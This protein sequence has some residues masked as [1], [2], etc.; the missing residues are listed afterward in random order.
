MEEIEAP[1]PIDINNKENYLLESKEYELKLDNDIYLLKMELKLND[2]ISLKIRQINDLSFY[3]YSKD[4]KYDNLAKLLLLNKDYYDNISKIYKF[5]DK[6]ISKK[7]VKLIKTKEKQIILLLKNIIEFEEVDCKL[8]LNEMTITNEEMIKILFNEIREIKIKNISNN[9]DNKEE[10]NNKKYE[11]L[12]SKINKLTEKINLLSEKNQ[13]DKKENEKRISILTEKVNILLEENKKDKKEYELKIN[14]LNEKVNLL[15]EENKKLQKLS[16]K[17]EKILNE[18]MNKINKEKEENDNFIKKNIN[19]D[20]KDN[21]QNLKFNEYLTSNHSAANLANF[22]VYIGLK[23]HIEYLI[24]NNKSNYNLEIMRIKDKTIITSLKGHNS[25]TRV[26]RYYS[27]D[28]KEEY[29][30]SC[31]KDKLVIIWDIQNNFNKK[32]T[33]Q[34]K[35]KGNINDALL[36][37]N[38]FNNNYILLSSEYNN[39]YS[40]LYEFKEKT[41]YV[42]NIYRTNENNTYFIIPW[43]YKNKYYIIECGYQ[44]ISVNNMLED[45][46]YAI[47]KKDP[48]SNHFWGYIFNDNYLCVSDSDNKFIRI[49]DLVNKIIYKQIRYEADYSFGII[50]WNNIYTIVACFDCFVII[51]IEES[52][53]V[54]KVKLENTNPWLLTIRKIKT[55][56]LGECLIG[57][58]SYNNIRLFSL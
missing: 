2:I 43:L 4:Y 12:E 47:L 25:K 58:D 22:D 29:I 39:E 14:L 9:K 6:A 5:F 30:L 46:N 52:K 53:M 54:K 20:F 35:Y 8:N 42:K 57:S 28:N 56:Q 51:N 32:Y 48:D 55:I 23:D 41:K 7:K 33:I 26:I 45:E 37:F 50:P 36:L 31:D 16:Y 13:K 40:K 34:S 15:I 10:K 3:Y 44:I 18:R 27:K 38:I 21:P 1:T 19:V 49:W 17:F 11:D 24:Y